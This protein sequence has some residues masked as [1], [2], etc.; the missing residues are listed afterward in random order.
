MSEHSAAVIACSYWQQSH[1]DRFTVLDRMEVLRLTLFTVTERRQI[2]MASRKA[3]MPYA[4]FLLFS[5]DCISTVRSLSKFYKASEAM[6]VLRLV[7]ILVKL[8]ASRISGDLQ[9]SLFSLRC[10]LDPL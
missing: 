7:I 5:L 2:N 9:C 3:Y 6:C 4:L 10:C 8:R 1:G